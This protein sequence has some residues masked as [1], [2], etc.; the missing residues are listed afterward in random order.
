MTLKKY[1]I[2][3]MILLVSLLLI[4]VGCDG[5]NAPQEEASTTPEA[6]ASEILTDAP[7]VEENPTE[8]PAT[9]EI[10]TDE[11]LTTEEIPVHTGDYSLP[12]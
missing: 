3:A 10:T 6:S 7:T 4:L 12:Y 1:A 9:E 5:G 2:L 8:A 11:E